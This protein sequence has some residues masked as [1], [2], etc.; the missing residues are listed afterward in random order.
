MSYI[1]CGFC[2]S[3]GLSQVFVFVCVTADIAIANALYLIVFYCALLLLLK[4]QAMHVKLV[5]IQWKEFVLILPILLIFILIMIL[6][7]GLLSENSDAWWHMSYA[8]KISETKF[9]VSD[10][11]SFNGGRNCISNILFEIFAGMA[12]HSCAYSPRHQ[13]FH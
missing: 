1:V 10:Q 5:S 6:N 13:V 11:A 2:L 3:L 9:S 8:K 7:G 12:S 4:Y